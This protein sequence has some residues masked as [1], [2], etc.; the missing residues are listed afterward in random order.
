MWA[1][2]H[3]DSVGGS[4]NAGSTF[5]GDYST[6]GSMGFGGGKGV[7]SGSG[8]IG[9]FM[10]RPKAEKP[11]ENKAPE[12]KSEASKAPA[13]VETETKATAPS[14]KANPTTSNRISN[15]GFN[16]G[17]VDKRGN[18]LIKVNKA[19]LPNGE[20]NNQPDSFE[21]S[22]GTSSRTNNLRDSRIALLEQRIK[23]LDPELQEHFGFSTKYKHVEY[24]DIPLE[25]CSGGQLQEIEDI[26]EACGV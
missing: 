26:L 12:V 23:Q 20:A 1:N 8:G 22:L 6:N 17:S 14:V 10:T 9:S 11:V 19:S 18:S 7:M 4:S 5:K 2:H 16:S 15:G 13:P 21:G 3:V 24:K 25:E